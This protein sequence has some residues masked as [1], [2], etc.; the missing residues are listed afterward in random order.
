MSVNTEIKDSTPCKR[1]GEEIYWMKSKK[2]TFY[3]ANYPSWSNDVADDFLHNCSSQVPEPNKESNKAQPK[4]ETAKD[5]PKSNNRKK[6]E[7]N[8]KKSV[9]ISEEM[10]SDMV[11]FLQKIVDGME[12]ELLTRLK[13]MSD[14]SEKVEKL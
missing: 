6:S 14:K 3:P 1:C 9:I 2:G 5:L 8:N 4:L 7:S 13:D 11:N 12:K 10:V